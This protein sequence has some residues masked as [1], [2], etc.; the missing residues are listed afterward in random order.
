M[1][2]TAVATMK[3]VAKAAGVSVATVSRVLNDDD[4]VAGETRARVQQV[5][6]QLGYT[7]NTLEIGRASC[8][9]RV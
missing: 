5:I 1:G 3:D 4:R 6:E 9:E 2:V 8:R 7:P